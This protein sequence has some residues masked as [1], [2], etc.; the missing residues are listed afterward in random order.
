MKFLVVDDSMTMRK[1]ACNALRR[2][3]YDDIVEAKDGHDAIGMLYNEKVD[4]IITDWNMPRMS[5]LEFAK[6][7]RSEKRL[8]H[9]P[10]LMV[11]TRGQKKDVLQALKARVNSYIL[12]PFTPETLKGKIEQIL[13]TI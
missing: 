11:T 1:I 6:F 2:I 9:L 10:I 8:R 12:K 5:G 4:F 3:G 7:V 13:K